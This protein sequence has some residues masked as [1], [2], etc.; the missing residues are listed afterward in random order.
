MIIVDIDVK[1]LA[2]A[3]SMGADITVDT[4]KENLTNVRIQLQQGTKYPLHSK[5]PVNTIV[6]ALIGLFTLSHR[7]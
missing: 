5:Y 3:K 2:Q 7:L 1:R 6:N 4:T